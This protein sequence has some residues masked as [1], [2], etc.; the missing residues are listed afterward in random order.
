V[1][2]THPE[3]VLADAGPASLKW[4]TSSL[5]LAAQGWARSIELG[6][7]WDRSAIPFHVV[8]AGERHDLKVAIRRWS[9]AGAAP[10]PLDQP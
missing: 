9:D 3:Q 6:E 2:I 8:L 7:P 4:F 1:V 5:G 10:A